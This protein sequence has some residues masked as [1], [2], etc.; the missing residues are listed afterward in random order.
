[1]RT[2]LE[3]LVTD[4][5]LA[6]HRRSFLGK[7]GAAVLA[8]RLTEPGARPVPGVQPA[9]SLSDLNSGRPLVERIP[10]APGDRSASPD[11]GLGTDIAALAEVVQLAEDSAIFLG[12]WALIAKLALEHESVRAALRTGGTG[13]GHARG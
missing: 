11:G 8:A 7:C 5:A 2:Q 10:V 4:N 6:A 13:P 9:S 12:R 3:H 1:M